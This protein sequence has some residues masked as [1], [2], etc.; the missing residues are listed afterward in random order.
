M[1]K[2]YEYLPVLLLGLAVLFNVIAA[3][4]F[5]TN[6][7]VWYHVTHKLQLTMVAFAGITYKPNKINKYAFV[8]Y[9]SIILL[10]W[11]LRYV[12]GYVGGYEVTAIA[13]I[14]SIF[15]VNLIEPKERV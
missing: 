5:S 6:W 7:N 13:F 4:G 2:Y 10:N 9:I 1:K 14:I 15:I 12:I 3:E 11:F 8:A